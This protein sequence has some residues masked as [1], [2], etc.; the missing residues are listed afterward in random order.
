MNRNRHLGQLAAA[1]GAALITLVL[2]L[3]LLGFLTAEPV[4]AQGIA[5][6]EISPEAQT[7]Y[8]QPGQTIT[9]IITVSN[10]GAVSAL[11]GVQLEVGTGWL[12]KYDILSSTHSHPGFEFWP[13]DVSTEVVYVT[14][15]ATATPG[16]A[17]TSAVSHWLVGYPESRV[18]STMTTIVA[19]APPP[20][21]RLEVNPV[22]QSKYAQPGQEITFS[23]RLTNTGEISAMLGVSWGH[24][25]NWLWK[26]EEQNNQTSY[27]FASGNTITEILYVSVPPTAT[28][29]TQDNIWG[30]FYLL[31]YP[32]S[33]VTAT[34]T[35][36]VGEPPAT[37]C[38]VIDIYVK[39]TPSTPAEGIRVHLANEAGQELTNGT[40]GADGHAVWYELEP[41]TYQVWP[42]VADGEISDPVSA[43]LQVGC[44]YPAT[45]WFEIR[46]LPM[47]VP[48]SGLVVTGP[49][50]G[51][52]DTPY[53]FTAT[54]TPPET[55]TPVTW[56]VQPSGGLPS[57]IWT[58]NGLTTS[59]QL[60]WSFV[61]TQSVVFTAD[62]GYGVVVSA[63][64]IIDVR[65][66][67][68]PINGSK[69]FLPL[70]CRGNCQQPT[71]PDPPVP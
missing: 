32:E 45:Q 69:I 1:I 28:E 62:N 19:G 22:A 64:H 2:A 53:V 8:A 49:I 4:N 27:Q 5:R 42:N 50:T 25:Q 16:T 65:A 11:L 57:G 21:A 9:Y 55:T 51:V 52:I 59:V 33:R 13:G 56:T 48:P 6:L 44:S 43:T 41:G 54:V 34:M 36:I 20:Q 39:Y 30:S 60:Q 12:W 3:G 35:T 23:F 70:L 7:K 47:S 31:G 66:E 40:T 15:P 61:G 29:G 38:G 63:T 24:G 26:E 17:G 37:E 46:P 14:V 18:T 10:T 58:T 71:N 67:I 68:I